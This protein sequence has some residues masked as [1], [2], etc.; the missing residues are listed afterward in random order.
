MDASKE[1]KDMDKEIKSLAK[2][3]RVGGADKEES[4]E[5]KLEKILSSTPRKSKKRMIMVRYC[6][7]P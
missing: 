4:K 6:R 3:K 2:T 5:S 1:K 7:C